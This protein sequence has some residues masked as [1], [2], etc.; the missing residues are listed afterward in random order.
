[1]LQGEKR[2]KIQSEVPAAVTKLFSYEVWHRVVWRQCT[3]NS[4]AY[5][6]SIHIRPGDG[7]RVDL[8]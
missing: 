4:E 5:S 6:V 2:D 3:G 1:L 8:L 7:T